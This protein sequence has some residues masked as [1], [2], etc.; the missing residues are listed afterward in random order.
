MLYIAT[1]LAHR[2]DGAN[3]ALIQLKHQLA[4]L[5]HAAE[6][7]GVEKCGTQLL[8][9]DITIRPDLHGL[10]AARAWIAIARNDDAL[11]ALPLS[12]QCGPR[13]NR[14]TERRT[15][16]SPRAFLGGQPRTRI[17]IRAAH[18]RRLAC[19]R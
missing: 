1:V 14:T 17:K 19:S 16:A 2:L 8:I 11:L 9:A 7:A 13:L 6:P 10:A 3:H 15:P 5:I 4:G 18:S 12:P